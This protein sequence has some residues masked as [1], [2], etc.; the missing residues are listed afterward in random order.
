MAG[1]YSPSY[2]CLK[3]T[4]AGYCQKKEAVLVPVVDLASPYVLWRSIQQTGR[5]GPNKAREISP[6]T[7]SFWRRAR[8][9]R[10]STAAARR[11]DGWQKFP[12]V[13]VPSCLVGSSRPAAASV[14]CLPSAATSER[15]QYT[16][17]PRHWYIDVLNKRVYTYFHCRFSAPPTLEDSENRTIAQTVTFE[18][19][20]KIEPPVEMNFYWRFKSNCL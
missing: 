8:L 18:P 6:P 2:A 5:P 1:E 17:G 20:V 15:T 11:G 10:T 14:A 16:T 7:P 9:S 13:R 3:D 4:A 12:G 19:P